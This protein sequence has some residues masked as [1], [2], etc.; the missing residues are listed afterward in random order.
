MFVEC[1][2]G[3]G[4]NVATGFD[5][6]VG[7]VERLLEEHGFKIY[8]RLNIQDIVAESRCPTF[9]RY[10][11]FGACNPQFARDLFSADPNIGLLMPCNVV[12]YERV[13]GGC[14]VM[15]KDPA[16]N[17]DLINNPLAIQASIAVK[18]HM[19]QIAETLAGP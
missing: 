13:E 16:R 17:M 8:T 11:I 4:A 18:E 9:G 1:A 12:I 6:T 10:V 3:F 14:A 5:E 2:Y 7:V 15:I 19:E